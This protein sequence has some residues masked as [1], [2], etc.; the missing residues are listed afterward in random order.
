MNKPEKE[1]IKKERLLDKKNVSGYFVGE[2]TKNG[3]KTGE[4][5]IVVTVSSKLNVSELKDEDLI[6]ETING[7]KTDVIIVPKMT[8]Q[9]LGLRELPGISNYGSFCGD[10]SGNPCP[11]NVYDRDLPFSCVP[12]GISISIDDQG[13]AGTLGGNF[14]DESNNAV[15]LT[16]A[17]VSGIEP[18]VPSL[19]SDVNYS[20]G[21]SGSNIT[22]LSEDNNFYLKPTFSL[23][24]DKEFVAGQLPK[25]EAGRKYIFTG[26]TALD[27]HPFIL[28][29][30]SVG[31]TLSGAITNVKIINNV[32]DEVLYE[33]GLE[34][35]GSGKTTP[36][37]KNQERMEFVYD[38]AQ[39]YSSLYYQCSRHTGMG[40]E[41]LVMFYGIP[42][43][44]STNKSKNSPEYTDAILDSIS[45]DRASLNV[46]VVNPA[47]MDD[48]LSVRHQI[49]VVGKTVKIKFNHQHND[50]PS[51][52]QPI[53]TVDAALINYNDTVVPIP[54]LRGLTN[55]PTR[56]YDP[57]YTSHTLQ[58][59]D[60]VYK[61]GRTTG[62]TP[63]SSEEA[64]VLATDYT[65]SINYCA[66]GTSIQ[67]RA[68]FENVLLYFQESAVG[69]RF[70]AAGD[71]GSLILA[72][73][74]LIDKVVG[75]HFAGGSSIDPAT[76][77]LIYSGI[78]C[79]I[80]EVEAALGISQ[81]DGQ[82][83]ISSSDIE[84]TEGFSICG[85]C[86]R[87]EGNTNG[88]K[89]AEVDLANLNEPLNKEREFSS[90]SDCANIFNKPLSN[91]VVPVS[92]NQR[93]VIIFDED[94]SVFSISDSIRL[95][96][97]TDIEEDLIIG[98]ISPNGTIVVTTNLLN[99]HP[100]GAF[101]INIT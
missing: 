13:G 49:G 66:A 65:V 52:S 74:F 86:Y 69:S 15:G 85:D 27:N 82:R 18:Y 95:S 45:H 35:N 46:R 81:W 34:K 29:S 62:V 38:P 33:N 55:Q 51:L 57:N 11:P 43:C 39:S 77:N 1:L 58:T 76:G 6:P 10:G 72:S 89:I 25:I 31:G 100:E 53:N 84:E 8:P 87:V 80:E 19:E 42:Y 92:A 21:I 70:S 47:P 44:H 30:S 26:T 5:A 23:D 78:G 68:D 12:G 3:K 99:S 32:T 14:L 22:F 90:G 79:K 96:P 67:E 28:T 83:C 73:L 50:Q 9:I 60:L 54:K 24:D 48:S 93:D 4:E 64:Y 37:L 61:T 71:S 59:A 56:N 75:L 16:N 36:E 88:V 63:H 20:I 7:K 41:V 101:V 17:H 2:K 94:I 91:L 98:S 97:G 40:N